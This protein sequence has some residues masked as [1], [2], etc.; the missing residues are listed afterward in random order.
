[1]DM[2]TQ[3]FALFVVAAAMHV[4]WL[5]WPNVMS[6]AYRTSEPS[7]FCPHRATPLSG[8]FPQANTWRMFIISRSVPP[9]K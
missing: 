5:W 8:L 9:P 7:H 3:P 6:A 1:M 2:R 4:A